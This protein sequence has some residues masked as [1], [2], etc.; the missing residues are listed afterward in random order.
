MQM[1][2][3]NG[4]KGTELHIPASFF[5]LSIAIHKPWKKPTTFSVPFQ[6]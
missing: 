2:R 4:F 3:V 5:S 6:G 1:V